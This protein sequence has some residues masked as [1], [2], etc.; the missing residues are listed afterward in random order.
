MG[1]RLHRVKVTTFCGN[2]AVT[3]FGRLN[4]VCQKHLVIAGRDS[5]LLFNRPPQ[6]WSLRDVYKLWGCRNPS[7]TSNDY[8]VV[9]ANDYAGLIYHLTRQTIDQGV[10]FHDW[11]QKTMT[12]RQKEAVIKETA[13]VLIAAETLKTE[14]KI[15]NESTEVM[16]RTL[17]SH[18]PNSQYDTMDEQPSSLDEWM[19]YFDD[20]THHVFLAAHRARISGFPSHLTCELIR[21]MYISAYQ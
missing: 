7:A 21:N 17:E 3:F 11:T 18:L 12:R 5:R 14:L 20:D 6:I 1:Y 9:L 13:C 10:R 16:K 8:D 4:E 15:Q 19:N 2:A